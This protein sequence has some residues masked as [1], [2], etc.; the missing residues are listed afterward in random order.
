M[1][2]TLVNNAMQAKPEGC[3][4]NSQERRTRFVQMRAAT[5]ILAA[6]EMQL[7]E[8]FCALYEVVM[9][10][11]PCLEM[12]GMEASS[13]SALGAF[14]IARRPPTLTEGPPHCSLPP[15]QMY[16]NAL[17]S[18]SLRRQESLLARHPAVNGD[19]R[20]MFMKYQSPVQRFGTLMRML[21]CKMGK[22]AAQNRSYRRCHKHALLWL[23][24][25]IAID[26]HF[27]RMHNAPSPALAGM[28]YLKT[29][30]QKGGREKDFAPRTGSPSVTLHCI[31]QNFSVE[32]S[33]ESKAVQ[34]F[35]D[36][37]CL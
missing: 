5:A 12:N 30:S 36:Q 14:V 23:L 18:L 34:T 33:L 24:S 35:D 3:N 31:G 2:W 25:A 10:P 37:H 29:S 28:R 26:I 16:K 8:V 22:G 17:E 4:S 9:D 11:R 7:S 21:Y 15:L 19:L 1:N 32:H 13:V 6:P 20:T 27:F